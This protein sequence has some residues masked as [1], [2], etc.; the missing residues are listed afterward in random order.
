MVLYVL[1]I[2]DTEILFY[3]YMVLIV[4]NDIYDTEV[5]FYTYVRW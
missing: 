3:S 4:F 1:D 5:L 2:Y